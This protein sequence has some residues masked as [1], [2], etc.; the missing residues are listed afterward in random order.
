MADRKSVS[1][2]ERDE[3]KMLL[4]E[5]MQEFYQED[6]LNCEY[7]DLCKLYNKLKKQ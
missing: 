1:K 2:K 6:T 3:F 7:S 4:H 5:A